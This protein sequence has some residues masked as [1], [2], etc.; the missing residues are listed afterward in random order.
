[1]LDLV[2]IAYAASRQRLAPRSR[3][4]VAS[5]AVQLDEAHRC[6]RFSA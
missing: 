2:L 4:R 3:Y 5:P 6:E 1:M